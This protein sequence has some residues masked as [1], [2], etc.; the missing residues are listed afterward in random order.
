MT[1]A[2]I[3]LSQVQERQVY[4]WNIGQERRSI[5]EEGV[6][7]GSS[8]LAAYEVK[9][10]EDEITA[11]NLLGLYILPL[12]LY[13]FHHETCINVILEVLPSKP[14]HSL[15]SNS[16][17]KVSHIYLPLSYIPRL[18]LGGGNVSGPM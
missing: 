10:K 4:Q 17:Q 11:L 18:T 12:H 8:W 1:K 6:S 7:N 9:I 2:K 16:D 15:T 14:S 3:D 13:K 5:V